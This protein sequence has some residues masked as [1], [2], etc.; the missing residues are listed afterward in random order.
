[1]A[2][3][4]SLTGQADGQCEPL[5][6]GTLDGAC[7]SQTPD[8]CG[9]T[10]TCDGRGQCEVYPTTTACGATEKCIGTTYTPGG[11]CDGKGLCKLGVPSDCGPYTCAGG[12]CRKN[13]VLDTDCAPN[14]F[15]TTGKCIEAVCSVDGWCWHNPRPH[16]SVTKGLWSSSG[17]SAWAV[18][19]NGIIMRWDG[20]SWHGGNALTPNDL[21]DI[22]G[23]ADGTAWAV[24]EKGTTLHWDGTS[25]RTVGSGTNESLV[26]VSVPSASEAWA[27]GPRAALHWDGRS[28]SPT[29]IAGGVSIWASANGDVWVADGSSSLQHLS[30]GKWSGIHPTPAPPE[31]QV[32]S[33]LGSGSDEVWAA[34]RNDKGLCGL[35]SWNSKVWSTLKDQFYCLSHPLSSPGPRE[36]WVD[37]NRWKDGQFEE[38]GASFKTVNRLWART[39]TDVW[40]SN[41]DGLWHSDGLS[42]RNTILGS[43]DDFRTVSANVDGV[44]VGGSISF[45][46]VASMLS[47]HG[48]EW[49]REKTPA[50]SGAIVR[51]W[52][53]TRGRLPGSPLIFSEWAAEAFGILTKDK[54]YWKVVVDAL[55]DAMD[56]QPDMEFAAIDG[57]PTK[58][59][60]YGYEFFELWGVGKAGHVWDL[61]GDAPA[62]RESGVTEDLYD[63]A[64]IGEDDVWAVGKA[65]R[66]IHWKDGK[67][68]SL[69]SNASEGLTAVCGI[70]TNDVWAVGY[71]T[72]GGL[73][74]HWNG[75]AWAPAIDGLENGSL[76]DAWCA[77]EGEIWAISDRGDVYRG[78]GKRWTRQRAV[79]WSTGLRALSGSGASVWVVGDSGAVLRRNR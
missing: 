52:P 73:A 34:A 24:G 37:T 12:A 54:D 22:S 4:K 61:A 7:T 32:F 14:S 6:L 35:Y 18:A 42:W 10:G 55:P 70:Q 46:W 9:R 71:D 28:W 69:H 47:W 2:C 48:G 13:C 30:K 1:M 19:E 62:K 43:R 57:V 74:L 51:V 17:T 66:I 59:T 60:R 36:V 11:S 21:N 23:A 26:G 39:S 15:C 56:T 65:G 29:S 67:W 40:L 68:S 25:W 33:V 5:T 41:V 53:G 64:A 49:T 79:S 45:S 20:S 78:D 58:N 16:G 75:S 31:Y 27:I 72:H 38:L 3:S 76:Q 63:V 77:S 44:V 8:S 50:T